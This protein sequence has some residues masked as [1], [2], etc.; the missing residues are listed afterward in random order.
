MTAH[1][2]HAAEV[3]EFRLGSPFRPYAGRQG[4]RDA[5]ASLGAT[6]CVVTA[7]RGDRLIGRTVTSVFSLSVD[8]PSIL[9][10]IA[11]GSELAEAIAETYGFSFAML[12]EPQRAIADAFAGRGDPEKRFDH[13]N[14]TEWPSGHPRLAGAVAAMDCDLIGTMETET[15][16]LFAGGGTGVEGNP[17]AQPLIWHQRAYKGLAPL[18]AG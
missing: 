9:I 6:A 18:G 7:R 1:D 14:W 13:G 8:P 2:P 17:D 16:V 10:S 5:M 3:T 12:A 11:I 4:F 15:H